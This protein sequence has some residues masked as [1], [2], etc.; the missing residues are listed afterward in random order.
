MVNAV[1]DWKATSKQPVQ[2]TI[3][4][5][6]ASAASMLSIMVADSI[7]AHRN[8]KMMFHGAYTM[9]FGGKGLHEDTADLLGKINADIQARLV[10]RYNMAPEI[11]AEWFAEG[12]EG[13][14]S[15][16]D[17]KASGI[18]GEIIEDA[19]DVIQIRK[20][21]IEEIEGHGIGI[22]A[23]ME[24]VT[25][26][27]VQDGHANTEGGNDGGKSVVPVRP[28]D[29]ASAG[30]NG[31]GQPEAGNESGT[32]TEETGTKAGTD[33]PDAETEAKIHAAVEAATLELRLSF[34]EQIDTLQKA[35]K[36]AIEAGRQMQSERDKARDELTKAT[37][38]HVLTVENLTARLE[39]AN[40]RVQ[41]FLGTALA[42]SPAIESWQD[43][44]AS[45]AG[46]YAAAAK[47]YP[48][49]R[50]QYEKQN[51]KK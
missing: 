33:Q 6:A 48:D 41:R 17:M 10:S 39:A 12:R 16:D 44:L 40:T 49:L 37:A 27:E 21:E 26:K 20:E 30:D 9:S 35:A 50:R 1:R 23:L 7:K 32:G 14:L 15:A 11:V 38:A 31:S 34:A 43:A 24:N 36:T 29:G 2:V 22:A 42:F 8:A 25:E 47:Q 4:A 5:M 28:V 3:G 51:S 18:A 19:G 13:W 46:D 45:C